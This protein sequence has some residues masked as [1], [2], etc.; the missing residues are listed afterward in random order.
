[1]STRTLT[2]A[3]AAAFCLQLALPALA[4]GA[5]S[6]GA[7]AG[8]AH[9]GGVHAPTLNQGRKWATDAALRR[10]MQEIR[11]ALENAHAGAL[12]PA[13]SRALGKRLESQIISIVAHCKL[14]PAA[15]ASLHVILAELDA[16]AVA[17]K[18]ASG[19]AADKA[20]KRAATAVNAYGE[21]FDH[22]GWTTL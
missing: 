18:G 4:T 19:A 5:H 9:A 3:L 1:M 17:L 7:H 11:V 12:T 8:G 10:G 13:Q 6:H 20:L 22:P 2:A 21:Y 15:D 16:A 14:E